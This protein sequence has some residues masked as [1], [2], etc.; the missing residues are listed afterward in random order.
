MPPA[1]SKPAV[2]APATRTPASAL[3]VTVIPPSPPLAAKML[4]E[5]LR[6]LGYQLAAIQRAMR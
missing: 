3:V 4:R 2:A 5:G 1:P 6:T